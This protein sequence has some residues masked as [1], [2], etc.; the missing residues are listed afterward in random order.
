MKIDNEIKFKFVV[1]TRESE[2]NF[3]AHTATG[4]SLA[5]YLSP[6]VEVSLFANNSKGLPEVYNKAIDQSIKD[7][8]I[9]IFIHDDLHILDFHWMNAIFNGLH[10]FGVIGLAGNKRRLP[11]QPSWA[12]IDQ[13]FTWDSLNNLSG[14]V[15]HGQSFPPSNISNFGPPFQEVKLLDGLLLAAF[16]DTLIK[17]HIRFD[18]KFKFHFYD[19]DFCRQAEIQGVT[20]GTIPLSLIHESGGSFGSDAWRVSY[21]NYLKKWGE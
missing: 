9:L 15:G 5:P 1:A 6:T 18:E 16:S 11:F 17:N 21:R 7:P 13:N 19:L 8:A 12:F 4:R 20:M 2:G 10:H 14:L 3:W